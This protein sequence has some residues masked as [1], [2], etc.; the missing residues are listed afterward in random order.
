M[1]YASLKLN[2]GLLTRNMEIAILLAE[3]NQILDC[4]RQSGRLRELA[5][6]MALASVAMVNAPADAKTRKKAD[7]PTR[8]DIWN[9]EVAQDNNDGR[10]STRS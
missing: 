1:Y 4:F 10:V 3:D 9:I 5:D 7:G 2:R 8:L 6:A